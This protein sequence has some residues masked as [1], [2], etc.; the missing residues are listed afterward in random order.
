MGFMN[1][2][3]SVTQKNEKKRGSGRPPTGETPNRS[4]RLPEQLWEQIDD[5]RA[6]ERPIP[7]RSEAIRRLIELGLATDAKRARKPKAD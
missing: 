3:I 1:S 7:A 4:V 5:W 2:S 6:E